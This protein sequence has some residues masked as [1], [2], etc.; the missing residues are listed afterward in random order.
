MGTLVGFGWVSIDD[1]G[2]R[3]AALDDSVVQDASTLTSGLG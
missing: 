1:L 2:W 3:M